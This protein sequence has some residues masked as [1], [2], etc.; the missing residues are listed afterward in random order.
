MRK[1]LRKKR[2]KLDKKWQAFGGKYK[3]EKRKVF[4]KDQVNDYRPY[5]FIVDDMQ[6]DDT[7]FSTL[8]PQSK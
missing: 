5:L 3:W 7:K 2:E 6:D 4:G 1:R 8:D